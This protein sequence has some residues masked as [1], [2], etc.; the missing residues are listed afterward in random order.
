MGLSFSRYTHTFEKDGMVAVFHALKMKPVYFEVE[1]FDSIR[2]HV[3]VGNESV[4]IQKR[5]SDGINALCE[6]RVL[7]EE[8]NK[9]DAIIE[10]FRRSIPGSKIKIAYFIL[11]ES[12]NLSCKY[13]FENAPLATTDEP[14]LMNERT[15][16][17]SLDFF[18][19]QLI[20]NGKDSEDDAKDIIFYGGEPL[21]NL[22]VLRKILS[23]ITLRRKSK[24]ELWV[25]VGLSI[26][27]N[28]TL[29]TEEV[30]KEL[31]HNNVSIS[32]SVDGPKEITDASRCRA[33]GKSAFDTIIRGI[34]ACKK[35]EV[36]F[37]LSV[38]LSDAAVNNFKPV[39]EFID[40]TKPSSLGFNLL[41]NDGSLVGPGY[42][43]KAAKFLI[44]AFTKF[45]QSGMYEDRMMRKVKS[46]VKSEVYPFDCGACGGNQV[47]FSPTGKAGICH[48]YLHD[49]KYFPTSVAEKDFDPQKD[50]VYQEWAK[51]SPLFME[52]CQSCEA[53]GICGGGCPMNADI[54]SGS[55]WKMDE[56]FCVH[57][58]A[59]LKWLVWDLF[60]KA[61]K[62]D[63]VR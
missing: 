17:E 5:L 18:E 3:E 22:T 61:S 36:Q 20:K 49:K 13:C 8:P 37:G 56:R 48:G 16:L 15:A 19:R 63:K 10:Y 26:V 23:E 33:D 27:T 45:R 53:L 9:D 58:R 38:T 4:T 42:D 29:L 44:D 59:T 30:A 62:D 2:T 54:L 34:E 25:D 35:A 52:E 46:F 6:A 32:I 43:R 14:L 7:N 28:G 47:V 24:P 21:L 51:R 11:A 55:I 50:G 1:L 57:A 60:E 40:K 31:S 12:C 41:M 39:I